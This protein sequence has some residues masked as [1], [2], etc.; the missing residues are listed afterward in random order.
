MPRVTLASGGTGNDV[1]YA[2][3]STIRMESL[4]ARTITEPRAAWSPHERRRRRG[5]RHGAMARGLSP[6]DGGGSGP[7]G[8]AV[9]ALHR[10]A[11]DGRGPHV[12]RLDAE[13][14]AAPGRGHRRV[15]P[16]HRRGSGL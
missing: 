9:P 7:R 6:S 11:A 12:P 1:G 5:P 2:M 3:T 15:P 13:L 8:R 16:G 14:P 10:G 4:P